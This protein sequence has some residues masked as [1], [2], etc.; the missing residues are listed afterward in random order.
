MKWVIRLLIAVVLL[1]VIA[2]GALFA[3]SQRRGAGR[4]RYTVTIS[5]PASEVYPWLVEQDKLRKWVDGLVEVTD[6]NPGLKLGARSRQVL[7]LRGETTAL[8]VELTAVEPPKLL[9]ANVT[10]DGFTESIRYELTEEGQGTRV[11]FSGTARYRNAFLQ[12]MEP[13]VTPEAQ[14]KVEADLLRLKGTLESHAR[15][16]R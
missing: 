12:M 9:T 6:F 4:N 2:A 5:R 13:L 7:R 3:F 14:K 10:G 8:D 11:D 16:A 15:Y 1:A